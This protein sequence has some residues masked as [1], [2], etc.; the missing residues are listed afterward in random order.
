MKVDQVSDLKESESF[1]KIEWDFDD[2]FYDVF[3]YH[4]TSFMCTVLCMYVCM[5][6]GIFK[7]GLLTEFRTHYSL[8]WFNFLKSGLIHDERWEGLKWR[9]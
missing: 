2:L 4:G 8:L 5:Y 7:T 3:E 9:T 1:K 6:F